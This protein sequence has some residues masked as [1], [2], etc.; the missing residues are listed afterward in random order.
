LETDHSP[1][2]NKIT[3]I[4]PEGTTIFEN[5]NIEWN[6]ENKEILENPEILPD[7]LTNEN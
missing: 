5:N 6:I 4:N 2:L 1:N 7:P 3:S